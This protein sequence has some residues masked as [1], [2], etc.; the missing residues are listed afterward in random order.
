VVIGI[1][2]II[3]AMPRKKEPKWNRRPEERPS[4]LAEA[5]L[6]LF[7][8]QGYFVTSIDDIARFAGATK[9]AVYHHYGSKEE[10]F[11]AA[12]TLYFQRSFAR[13]AADMEH[14]SDTDV[15]GRIE[16]LLRGGGTVWCSDEFPSILCLVL[17]E[18][19]QNVP[20]VRKT[21]MKMGPIRGRKMIAELIKRGQATGVVRTDVDAQAAARVMN[22]GLAFGMALLTSSGV[23]RAARQQQFEASLNAVLTMISI[24]KRR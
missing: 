12:I 21:F 3:I 14:Y 22:S 10:L 8:K 16:A 13:A 4:E 2:F 5:A 7:C 23:S 17:G 11:E 6:Q 9:G 1:R 15:L 18:P 19:G 24:A 20:H